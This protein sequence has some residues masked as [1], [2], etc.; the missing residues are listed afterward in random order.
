MKWFFRCL[1]S[2]WVRTFVGVLVASV[3]IW[4]CGPLIGLGSLHPFETETVRWIT[5]VAL[6]VGGWS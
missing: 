1:R 5:I 3:L 4:F 6:L 2:R